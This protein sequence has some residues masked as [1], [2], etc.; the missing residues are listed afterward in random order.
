[1]G[2]GR[3][4]KE[5][6]TSTGDLRPAVPESTLAGLREALRQRQAQVTESPV[7]VPR[8]AVALILRSAGAGLEILLIKRAEREGD[9]WSGHVAL[10]GGREEPTDRSLEETAIRETREET[11]LD[12][13]GSGEILGPLDDLAPRSLP[14]AILVRPFVALLREDSVL[15][16]SDEVAAAF[17]VPLSD[18]T[19][20]GAIS[21]STVYVGGAERR[22]TSFLHGDYVVWGM[23]E[24][25]LKQLLS[26]LTG[27]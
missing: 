14:R 18:L 22:V 3:G 19:A 4:S 13:V 20:P 12:L 21:E 27:V 23:T 1:V 7:D 24:R 10:P 9:P 17:W 16:L 26:V 15:E 8:A 5:A 11:G 6:G 25:I 2:S